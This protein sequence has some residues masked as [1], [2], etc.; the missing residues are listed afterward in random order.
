MDAIT[1]DKTLKTPDLYPQQGKSDA[2]IA[3]YRKVSLADPDDLTV[4]NTLGDLY[5]R[6]GRQG[7]AIKHFTRVADRFT[8]SGYFVKA[9]AM[10][11]KIAK[12][13]P[14]NIDLQL[15]MG[16]LYAKQS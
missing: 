9:I 11:K 6:Q 8:A 12:L 15:R 2:A 16:E 3:E 5:L 7:E 14:N 1:K 13:E 10:Y 4:A